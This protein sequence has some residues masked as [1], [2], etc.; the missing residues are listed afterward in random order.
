MLSLNMT[1]FYFFGSTL[2][3][4]P[5]FTAVYIKI[6]ENGKS[7]LFELFESHLRTIPD[8]LSSLYT[9]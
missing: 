6:S 8:K 2:T 1:S 9:K 3:P 7:H 5:G 4:I